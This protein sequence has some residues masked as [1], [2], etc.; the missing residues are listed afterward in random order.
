MRDVSKGLRPGDRAPPRP[1]RGRVA[2]QPAALPGGQ[3]HQRHEGGRQRRAERQR[4]RRL[5][6]RG[7]PARARLGDPFGSDSGPARRGRSGRS[8]RSVPPARARRRAYV[9]RT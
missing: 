7:V 2:E 9:F 6:G 5:V 3:R 4:A 1:W 8:R